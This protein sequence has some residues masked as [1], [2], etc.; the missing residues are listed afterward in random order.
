MPY[1]HYTTLDNF[2]SIYHSSLRMNR[3]D[4]VRE[5][6][7]ESGVIRKFLEALKNSDQALFD[8]LANKL[9][10]HK[11]LDDIFKQLNTYRSNSYILCL[12]KNDSNDHLW[13]E[14]AESG[15]GVVI[16]IRDEYLPLE[17]PQISGNHTY[18]RRNDDVTLFKMKYGMAEFRNILDF[19]LYQNGAI[20]QSLYILMDLIKEETHNPEEEVRLLYWPGEDKEIHHSQNR[21]LTQSEVEIILE[22]ETKYV[23]I[24]YTENESSTHKLDHLK[25]FAAF[26][27]KNK[28]TKDEI[29]DSP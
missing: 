22:Y 9:G 28:K 27:C 8:S 13:Q 23:N 6:G 25:S 18:N 17:C 19:M 29:V 7:N 26:R 10:V 12:S 16:Q 24:T 4:K 15:K 1:Y 11:N 2:K 5:D 14:Y 20:E 21:Y 3:T